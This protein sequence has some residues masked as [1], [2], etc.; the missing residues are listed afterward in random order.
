MSY[1]C[2]VVHCALIMFA[3]L[4]MAFGGS[5]LANTG[6]NDQSAYSGLDDEGQIGPTRIAAKSKKLNKKKNKAQKKSENLDSTVLISDDPDDK[7]T[8]TLLLDIESL[9][10]SPQ[11]K[12]TLYLSAFQTLEQAEDLGEILGKEIVPKEKILKD[13]VITCQ[14][15]NNKHPLCRGASTTTCISRVASTVDATYV[16]YGFLQDM[17]DLYLLTLSMIDV[18]NKKEINR[19]KTTLP[20]TAEIN[21]INAAVG[22]STCKLTRRYGCED[23]DMAAVAPATS[24]TAPAEVVV[25]PVPDTMVAEADEQD[26]EAMTTMEDEKPDVVIPDKPPVALD[27]SQVK[28]FKT[29][30]WVMIGLSAA[31]LIGGATC[32][33]LMYMYKSDYDAAQSGE[34]AKARDAKDKTLMMQWTSVG[35]YSVAGVTAAVGIPML[36]L[37]YMAEDYNEYQKKNA[38]LLPVVGPDNVGLALS[39][40]F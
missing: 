25:E 40:R 36:V 14:C 26:I 17:D 12:E 8:S 24:P 6:N 27:D 19:V 11:Q 4:S 28:L 38:L 34:G 22:E 29:T 37:G 1:S 15:L 16:I 9:Y 2:R 13:P 33:T 3:F 5:L 31:S 10:L 21:A 30:G 32:T 20:I 23:A 35:L 18:K 7:P 39:G